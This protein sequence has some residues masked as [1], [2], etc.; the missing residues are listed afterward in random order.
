MPS[1]SNLKRVFQCGTERRNLKR[2]VLC[3][4]KIESR[5]MMAELAA[6]DAIDEWD[7]VSSETWRAAWL[8]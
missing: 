5:K 4:S 3:L 7:N 6:L 1:V 2:S 8:L